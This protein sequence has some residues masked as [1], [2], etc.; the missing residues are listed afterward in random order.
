MSGSGKN[1]PPCHPTWISSP[2]PL[3]SHW[4]F[5]YVLEMEGGLPQASKPLV[6]YRAGYTLAVLDRILSEDPSQPGLLKAQ[7]DKV[8]DPT[9]RIPTPRGPVTVES[10]R[11]PRP[12]KA[13]HH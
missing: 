4:R 10:L 11:S 13:S 5:A 3:T 2:S 12:S 9:G 7:D 8:T 1:Q 6:R